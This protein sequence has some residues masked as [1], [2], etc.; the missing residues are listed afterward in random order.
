MPPSQKP[1]P[2][3][4]SGGRK[5]EHFCIDWSDPRFSTKEPTFGELYEA[6]HQEGCPICWL[7]DRTVYRHLRTYCEENV[8]DVGARKKLRDANG[9]CNRHAHKL[10]EELDTLAVAITYADI[11]KKLQRELSEANP[12]YAHSIIPSSIRRRW[13]Y[14]RGHR[15][16]PVFA[17]PRSCPACDEQDRSEARYVSA[18]ITYLSDELLLNKYRDA[19]GLCL[20][21]LRLALGAALDPDTVRILA[22]VNLAAW[23]AIQEHLAE[24]VRK[25]DHLANHELLSETERRALYEVVDRVVG[26]RDVR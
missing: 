26:K 25:A 24:V 8:T 9:Y 7:A 18:L 15:E 21:H 5:V 4:Y 19:G 20:V 11:L 22:T 12:S 6:L 16:A 23:E 2:S 13:Y 14:Q 10:L 3:N 17:I 1:L